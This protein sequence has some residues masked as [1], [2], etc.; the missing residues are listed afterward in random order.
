MSRQSLSLCLLQLTLLTGCCPEIAERPVRTKVVSGGIP[1][2]RLGHALGTY[3]TIEGVRQERGKVG[4]QTLLV[5]KVNGTELSVPTSVW[6]DNVAELPKNERCI[7]KGYE[8][9]KMIGIPE[10]VAET[11]GTP[12][13]PAAWQF[14]RYFVVTSVEQPRSLQ[15]K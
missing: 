6:I 5:D 15:L 10:K 8:S 14:Y 13:P 1:S 2:G 12:L 3:L 4:S 9:G 7:F 11:T